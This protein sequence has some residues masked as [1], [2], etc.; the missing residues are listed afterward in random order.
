MVT[1]P[2][3]IPGE[4]KV[5]WKDKLVEQIDSILLAKLKVS[6]LFVLVHKKDGETAP[7]GNMYVE[8]V[9]FLAEDSEKI[10]AL[11]KSPA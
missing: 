2:V 3:T 7:V 8:S 6:R 10:K 5:L 11:L 9:A 1:T 4:G